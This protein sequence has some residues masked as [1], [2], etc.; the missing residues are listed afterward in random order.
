LAQ[1]YLGL[2]DDKLTLNDIRSALEVFQK[3]GQGLGE[4]QKVQVLGHAYK[5]AIERINGQKLGLKKLAMKV[6]SWITCTKRPLTTSELQ[7]ALA[8]KV[9]K[10]ELDR[11]DL[12]HI[13]DIVAVCLG[14]VTVDEESSIIRL[15]HYTTQEY[16]ERTQNQW[17]SSAETD[18]TKI[19]VTYL[20]FSVFESGFCQTDY[21]F[22]NRLRSNPLYDYAAHNWGYHA[23]AALAEVEPLITQLLESEAKVSSSSQAMMASRSYSDYSQSVPR[24]ITGL[25]LAAYFGLKEAMITLL[26]NGHDLNSKDSYGRTPLSYAAENGHEAVVKLLLEKGAELETK[27]KDYGQTPLS[28]AA[29]NGHEAVVKL[30]L[31]KG[32]ELETKSN[33]GRTPLSWA[34][35]RGHEAVVKLLLEKG[36]ELE[37]KDKDYG[38]TPLSWAAARGHEAVVK[39]LLEKG[40]KKLQ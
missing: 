37:T 14:L 18:I 27:D 24:Q 11:G 33:N 28:W 9:G 2:L 3:Q 23:C 10:S 1:I 6:L 21:E 39:L 30:L 29:E 36:A 12:P 31:E 32:A 35:A 38:Q 19:C 34:A 13:R 5:E 4:D 26:E 40:A 8:T 25:H 15:V 17:F 20:S 22:D 16:F 7:H